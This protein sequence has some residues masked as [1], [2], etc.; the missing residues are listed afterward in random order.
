MQPT[1]SSKSSSTPTSKEGRTPPRDALPPRAPKETSNDTRAGE[2]VEGNQSPLP[3][4]D[5]SREGNTIKPHA[6]QVDRIASAHPQ[7]KPSNH[8]TASLNQLS[9]SVT[10]SPSSSTPA[11]TKTGSSLIRAARSDARAGLAPSE[12]PRPSDE[13]KGQAYPNELSHTRPSASSREPPFP[14]EHVASAVNADSLALPRIQGNDG[15]E[16]GAKRSA[17]T[18]TPDKE[19]KRTT[20]LNEPKIHQEDRTTDTDT[21]QRR[22]PESS[23]PSTHASDIKRQPKAPPQSSVGPTSSSG[24]GRGYDLGATHL[25]DSSESGGNTG[26]SDAISS[27]RTTEASVTPQVSLSTQN[28]AKLAVSTPPNNKPTSS[29]KKSPPRP[30]TVVGDSQIVDSPFLSWTTPS[31][32]SVPITPITSQEAEREG[33]IRPGTITPSKPLQS[34]GQPGSAAGHSASRNA[35]PTKTLPATGDD[36][37][38]KLPDYHHHTE[39]RNP[40]LVQLDSSLE[41]KN[42]PHAKP[43]DHAQPSGNLSFVSLDRL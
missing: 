10:L 27:L 16:R 4:A 13:V 30:P 23:T 37:P 8:P 11:I 31:L 42:R 19:G 22:K 41:A 34:V 17:E 6:Q 5:L 12:L 21:A 33:E 32:G 35:P 7:P 20:A 39:T 28:Q 40:S 3:K 43:I 9:A 15:V 18:L 14:T 29:R 25:P 2:L 24:V 38:S 26:R 36:T 1:S